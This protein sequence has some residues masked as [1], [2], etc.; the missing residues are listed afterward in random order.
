[1]ISTVTRG[2]H[3]STIVGIDG[4]TALVGS[5]HLWTVFG[6]GSVTIFSKKVKQRYTDGDNVPLAELLK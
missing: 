6:Q 4:T 1:M 3:K 5:D 2:K